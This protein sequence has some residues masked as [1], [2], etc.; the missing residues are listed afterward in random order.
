MTSEA[1][2]NPQM[3]SWRERLEA[4]LANLDPDDDTHRSERLI[5]AS[6]VIQQALDEAGLDMTVVGGSAVTVWRPDDW[7]SGDIDF[8]GAA[9]SAQ[10]AEVLEGKFGFERDGRHWI[11]AALRIFV[12]RPGS[13]LQPFGAGTVTVPRFGVK[14]RVISIED[15]IIDRAHAWDGSGDTEMWKQAADLLR[16]P[17]ADQGKVEEKAAAE[18]LTEALR[19]IRWLSDNADGLGP[20]DAKDLYEGYRATRRFEDG[21]A[22]VIAARAAAVEP[23]APDHE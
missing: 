16:Y 21:E 10:V 7:S 11:D 5:R 22:A 14:V 2:D 15:L 4:E 19:C 17:S 23:A 12:E 9:A 13:Q 20:H 6:A 18:D 3:L 8:V 1:G